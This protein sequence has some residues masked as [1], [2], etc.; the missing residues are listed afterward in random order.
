MKYLDRE[1]E[2][3]QKRGREILIV[4]RRDSVKDGEAVTHRN[5]EIMR[6]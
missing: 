2:R 5:K 3:A 1:N 4:R 6:K